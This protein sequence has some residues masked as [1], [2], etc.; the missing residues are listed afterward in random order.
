MGKVDLP[1]VIDVLE[2]ADGLQWI[3]VELDGTASAPIAP[4][5][6]ARISKEYLAKLGYTFRPEMP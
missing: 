4:F 1:A 5:E 6:C 3:M 2:K